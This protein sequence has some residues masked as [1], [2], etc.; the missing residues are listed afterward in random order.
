MEIDWFKEIKHFYNTRDL[1][2][3]RMSDIDRI[4]KAVKRNKIN[5]EQF[6]KITGE[7]YKK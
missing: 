1:E 6:K 7:D 2:G 4:K 5:E 3:N